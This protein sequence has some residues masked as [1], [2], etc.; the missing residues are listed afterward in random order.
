MALARIVVLSSADGTLVVS[1]AAADNED[2]AGSF[3][4]L[5]GSSDEPARFVRMLNV[6]YYEAYQSD[7]VL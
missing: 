5:A 3:A 1:V 4:S 6:D 2:T 7:V